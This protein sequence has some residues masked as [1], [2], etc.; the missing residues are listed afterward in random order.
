MRAPFVVLLLLTGLLAGC[1]DKDGGGGGFET[2]EQDEGAYIIVLT[3]DKT[4]DPDKAKVPK[5]SFVE[6]RAELEGCTVESDESGGPDSNQRS[7]NGLVPK[8][9]EYRWFAPSHADEYTVYCHLHRDKGM[10]MTLRVE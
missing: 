5:D 7:S 10:E 1:S 9:G 3:S 8:G 4:F 6:F 2:P